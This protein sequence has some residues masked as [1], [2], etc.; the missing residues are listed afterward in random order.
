[1]M[2]MGLIPAYAG[3]IGGAWDWLKGTASKAWTGLTDI[4]KDVW[5]YASDPMK[6]IQKV[7][8]NFTHL[9]KLAQPALGI[10]E[11]AIN[12]GVS[13]AENWIKSF[14]NS[15]TSPDGKV[16]GNVAQWLQRAMSITNTPSGFLGALEAIAM[17]ESGGNPHAINLWD[18]NAKA[19]HP[20]KGLMQTIDGTF[21]RY[22][23]AGLGDIWN[24][25]ANAVC[26][27]PLHEQ[28]LWFC[29]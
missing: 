26:C 9:G 19:G 15:F 28:P 17:H 6:L 5:S 27:Y 23:I 12:T 13:G 14:F 16:S 25:V 29:S 20:S 8:G 24:P 10:A 11:G 7:V 18:S 4:A 2:G 21:N 3:G 1:M 22:A